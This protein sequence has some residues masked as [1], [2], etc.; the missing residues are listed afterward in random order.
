M[1]LPKTI[2][3]AHLGESD[4]TLLGSRP[5]NTPNGTR[6][7]FSQ[8][9]V[10]I[11]TPPFYSS[12]LIQLVLRYLAVDPADRPTPQQLLTIIGPILTTYD[13]M[14]ARTGNIDAVQLDTLEPNVPPQGRCRRHGRNVVPTLT[15]PPWIA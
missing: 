9:A 4:I 2:K 11:F 8:L 13:A 15:T 12:H 7:I 6:T 14:N 1:L 10:T 3:L 5:P